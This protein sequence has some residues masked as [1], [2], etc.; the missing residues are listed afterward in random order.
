MAEHGR[1]E[2]SRAEQSR[3]EHR[4]HPEP[5]ARTVHSALVWAGLSAK[6]LVLAK[7]PAEHG[8]IACAPC[9]GETTAQ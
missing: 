3:A 5:A 7:R 4:G 8:L 9:V 6:V 1:A 2:Q